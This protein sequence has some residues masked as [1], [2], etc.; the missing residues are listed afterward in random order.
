MKKYAF[1]LYLG[2]VASWFGALGLQTVALPTLGL[3]YLGTGPTGLAILQMSQMLPPLLLLLFI[4]S[5][6]DRL[7]GRAMLV[8]IHALAAIPPAIL[9]WMVWNNAFSYTHLIIFALMMGVFSAFSIPT[10]DALLTRLVDSNI[11]QA[12]TFALLAQ[13]CAQLLSFSLAAVFSQFAGA[14]ALP[15]LQ[16][17]ALLAGLACSLGLPRLPPSNTKAPDGSTQGWRAGLDIALASPRLFP[18]MLVT[19]SIST[20]FIGTFLVGLPLIAR[21]VFGGSQFE[22]SILPLSFWGGTITSTLVLSR[23][24]PIIRRGRALGI[25]SFGG[26]ICLLGIAM[27]G[28]FTALCVLVLI[29]GIFAGVNMAMGRTIVQIEAPAYAKARVLAIYNLCFLGGMPIGALLTGVIAEK[30]GPQITAAIFACLMMITMTAILSFTNLR[31]IIRAAD[32]A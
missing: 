24:P 30:F 4:G 1:P 29:W 19:L 6:S 13:F 28:S 5:L 8:G 20:L 25:S 26:A 27:A 17:L 18:V 15:I 23:L 10:R 3:V 16:C 11:Q 31:H 21:S 32:E 14:W 12:V 9:G 7:E 22:L 2:G